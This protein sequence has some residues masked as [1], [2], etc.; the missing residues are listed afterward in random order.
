MGTLS[1]LSINTDTEDMLSPDLPFRKN[2]NA[3]NEAFPQFSDNIVVVV[4][5]PTADQANDAADILSENLKNQPHLFG[6]VYDPAGD[7]FF[8]QNGL[9]YLEFEEVEE[10]VDKL[11]TAQPFLGRLSTSPTLPELFRLIEQITEDRAKAISSNKIRV[12]QI[13]VVSREEA[14]GLMK[15]LKDGADFIGLARKNSIDSSRNSGGDLGFFGPGEMI[16]DFEKAAM[17]LEIDELSGIIETPMGFHI[18]K[19][20]E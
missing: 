11:L 8:R 14:V 15:L 3:L 4:D 18:I 16:P 17:K 5:A 10:L 1:F 2:S 12:R 19:R 13:V 7:P 20:V 6:D 9:M